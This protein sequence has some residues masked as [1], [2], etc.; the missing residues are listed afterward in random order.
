[1]AI[2]I[3]RMVTCTFQHADQRNQ[4]QP[5]HN[6]FIAIVGT[7]FS[8]RNSVL[9]YLVSVKGFV[10]V[11]IMEAG[12]NS[13]VVSRSHLFS[14]D[15]FLASTSTFLICQ[16]GEMLEQVDEP[17][18]GETAS[19]SS[20]PPEGDMMHDFKFP[21]V[22][23][24]KHVSFLSLGPGSPRIISSQ[25]KSE[26]LWGKTHQRPL[27]FSTPSQLLDHVT[28]NWESNFVTADLYTRELVDVFIKR[29]FFMLVSVDAP[30]LER[31]RRSKRCELNYF[32]NLKWPEK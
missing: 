8:G 20:A 31:F 32:S 13:D 18:T 5:N 1:M 30:V 15:A 3:L 14:R 6:M 16:N 21:D 12:L 25:S 29:P 2:I 4:D 27:C 24:N 28:R 26:F 19:D 17:V 10:A 7:R 22:T 11:R 9:E 23:R